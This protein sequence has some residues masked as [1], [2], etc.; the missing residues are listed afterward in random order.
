M[1]RNVYRFLS[2]GILALTWL[3]PLATAQGLPPNMPV[4]R[5]DLMVR[6]ANG[7]LIDVRTP[8]EWQQT[9]IPVTAHTIS[10]SDSD[11]LSQ[12][13]VLTSGD[14]SRRIAVICRSGDKSLE[15]RN[16]LLNS[17]YQNVTSVT[18]GVTGPDGWID[19]DLPV[20]P[21]R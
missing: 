10:F 14:R 4:S 18:G 16:A 1:S 20:R 9:G 7:L 13:D 2:A 17:G 21:Y 12:V 11:F 8:S 3:A 19:H 6:K 5:A 15:A